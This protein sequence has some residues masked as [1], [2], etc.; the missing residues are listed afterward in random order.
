MTKIISEMSDE[1]KIKNLT[2][3]VEALTGAKKIRCRTY[4]F[5]DGRIILEDI[6]VDNVRFANA[7][8]TNEYAGLV[9]EFEAEACVLEPP[10]EEFFS[11]VIN[12][13][14]W[15]R[16]DPWTT[17]DELKAQVQSLQKKASENV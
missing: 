1:L 13:E 17:I 8:G 15:C 16:E 9:L 7:L 10:S 2:R 6:E 4:P 14:I 5:G 3:L 12:A 11:V